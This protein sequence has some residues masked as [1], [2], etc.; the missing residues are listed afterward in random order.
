[1]NTLISSYVFGLFLTLGVGPV[2]IFIFN[3]SA[4]YGFFRGIV[5]SAGASLADAILF[6]LGVRGILSL[7]RESSHV[8][9]AL[10]LIGGVALLFIGIR[11]MRGATAQVLDSD[12]AGEQG[13]GLLFFKSFILTFVNPMAVAFFAFAGL[14]ILPKELLSLPLIDLVINSFLVGAGTMTGLI[15]ISGIACYIGASLS[16]NYLRLISKIAG[17]VFI[18]VGIYFLCDLA[19]NALPVVKTFL[20]L[21]NYLFS[22]W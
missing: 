18:L 16:E 19:Y 14:K 15:V 12:H 13:I 11:S 22:L 9:L 17:V 21:K 7:I 5:V 4:L 20:E 2:F 6:A 1:M 10:D 3:I 8:L